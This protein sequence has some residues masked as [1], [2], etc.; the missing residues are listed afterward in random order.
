MCRPAK[1]VTPIVSQPQIT[2][3]NLP[4][5]LLTPA[6]AQRPV[7]IGEIHGCG[8]EPWALYRRS[9]TFTPYT[10]IVNLTGQPAISLPLYQ[11]A[12]GLPSPIQLIGRPAAEGPLLSLAAQLEAALPWHG[13]RPEHHQRQC[14][15][16]RVHYWQRHHHHR[17]TDGHHPKSCRRYENQLEQ[18]G[19]ENLPRRL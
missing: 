8:E 14:P 7:P 13:R 2:L 15:R 18:C 12:D 1:N 19:R 3:G 11:G 6:L 16:R 10:A 4:D 17:S 9:A 5:A